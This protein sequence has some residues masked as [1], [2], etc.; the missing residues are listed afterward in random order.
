M[1]EERNEIMRN[2]TKQITWQIVL[3]VALFGF[4]TA[5]FAESESFT[6]PSQSRIAEVINGEGTVAELLEGASPQ[7]AAV[8]MRAMMVAVLADDELDHE[9]TLSEI[10]AEAV[11]AMSAEDQPV[12]VAALAS[13]V[14]ST[15]S[16]TRSASAL[17]AIQSGAHRGGAADLNLGAVFASNYSA[18]L[19]TSERRQAAQEQVPIDATATRTPPVDD[20]EDEPE[21]EPDVAPPYTGQQI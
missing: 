7:Q 16:I 11:A 6:M 21:D 13:E 20:V 8:I 18:A 5:A 4:T 10:V 3:A 19:R 2:T 9:T 15:P 1:Q 14:A 12:F 17:S